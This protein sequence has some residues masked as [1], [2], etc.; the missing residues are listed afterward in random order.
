MEYL[1]YMLWKL[2]GMA[3]LAFVWGVF[4]GITGRNL[5]GERHAA[6]SAEQA[7]PATEPRR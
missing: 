5:R 1:D 3:L 4:C 6:G 7:P 2:A